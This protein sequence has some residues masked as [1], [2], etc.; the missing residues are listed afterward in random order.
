MI[1]KGNMPMDGINYH[2]E[3]ILRM[4]WNWKQFVKTIDLLDKKDVR[5]NSNFARIRIFCYSD[6]VLIYSLENIKV[7]LCI[8]VVLVH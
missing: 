6:K 2:K 1:Y 7:L 4:I 3:P 8:V 5:H